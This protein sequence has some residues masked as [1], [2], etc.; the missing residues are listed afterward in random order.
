[1][2]QTDF[3]DGIFDDP[4]R[5]VR[6]RWQDGRVLYAVAANAITSKGAAQRG[7]NLKDFGGYPARPTDN[8]V[9]HD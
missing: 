1:M 9:I 6:E 4:D 3:I 7:M 8:G 2:T 5:R